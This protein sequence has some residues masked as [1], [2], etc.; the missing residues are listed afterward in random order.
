M[1]VLLWPCWLADSL[2]QDHFGQLTW[3]SLC[4]EDETDPVEV[5]IPHTQ[6][7]KRDS[8]FLVAWNIFYF[9][10]VPT[11]AGIKRI[12]RKKVNKSALKYSQLAINNQEK[13]QTE[14]PRK[15]TVLIFAFNSTHTFEKSF[16]QDFSTKTFKTV[17]L[18]CQQFSQRST[19][20][21]FACTSNLEHK[22]Q[23]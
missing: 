21:L 23:R 6:K 3:I 1:A 11:L 9:I 2:T 4:S 17:S 10:S 12:H 7:H 22:P 8:H 20:W 14:F 13:K 19:D 5:H 18:I 16:F 15:R